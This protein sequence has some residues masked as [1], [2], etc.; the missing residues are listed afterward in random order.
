MDNKFK[1]FIK[2]DGFYVILFVCL[3]IVAVVAAFTIRNVKSNIASSEEEKLIVSVNDNE[4][5][6]NKDFEESVNQKPNAEQVQNTENK[7]NN[8]KVPES[9]S[10]ANT[11]N[12]KFSNPIENGA[13]VREFSDKPVYNDTL[14][15]W[16]V[17]KGV[18][19]SGEKGKPVLA[20][21]E[22]KVVESGQGDGYLGNYV[23]IA[24]ANGMHTIYSNLDSEGLIA[25]GTV[26]K[27][28]QQIGKVGNSASNYKFEKYG[29]HVGLQIVKNSSN[30][31]EVEQVDPSKHIKFNKPTNK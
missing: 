1:K 21:A 11:T 25:K 10:V 6:K 29:D 24:H 5:V 12:V 31:K 3:C 9:K 7:T 20:S 17:A 13:V 22:G 27:A 8:V 23:K 2:K 16:I 18:S 26:V 30:N 4:D 28:K 14:E 19:I 15:Q